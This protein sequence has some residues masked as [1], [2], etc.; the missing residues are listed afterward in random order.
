MVFTIKFSII[1][2]NRKITVYRSNY[3]HR[4]IYS[5]FFLAHKP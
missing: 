5:C 4:T 2:V 3:R 1:F